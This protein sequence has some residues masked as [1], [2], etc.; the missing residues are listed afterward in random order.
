MK[1]H[2]GGNNATYRDFTLDNKVYL[3]VDDLVT[4]EIKDLNCEVIKLRAKEYYGGPNPKNAF[5]SLYKP[6]YLF[7]ELL[8][9]LGREGQN[10]K[11]D[12]Q[13]WKITFDCEKILPKEEV[14]EEEEHEE[15]VNIGK[16]NC[17]MQ[18]QISQVPGQ[19]KHCVEFKRKAGSALLFYDNAKRII[20]M[21]DLCN[22]TTH[23]S[24]AAIVV[25]EQAAA[26][27]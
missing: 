8:K 19:N 12:D 1:Q 25:N 14:V 9:K 17:S 21:M 6:D 13:T 15:Y 16:E 2:Q 5:F 7:E 10:F 4:Q 22:N 24:V 27:Q 11:V 26:Q 20:E 3:G 18:V 23:D